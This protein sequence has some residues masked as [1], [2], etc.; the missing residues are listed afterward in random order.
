MEESRNL[1]QKR[2]QGA[3]YRVS[4]PVPIA[5]LSESSSDN[6]DSLSGD[7]DEQALVDLSNLEKVFITGVLDELKICFYYN[8]LHEQ[9][10]MRVLLADEHSLFEFRAIGGQ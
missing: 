6:E 9:S 1:W 7:H 4:G 3:I 10:F 8:K 5:G 2:L